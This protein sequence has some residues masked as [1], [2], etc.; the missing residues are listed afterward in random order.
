MNKRH[1]RR[2]KRYRKAW[3]KYLKLFGE[4]LLRHSIEYKGKPRLYNEHTLNKGDIPI[5]DKDADVP[6]V[7]KG[8]DKM[9]IIEVIVP[10]KV[11]VNV[12]DKYLYSSGR[13]QVY[14]EDEKKEMAKTWAQS[15]LSWSILP[16]A[17]PC[18][19][20]DKCTRN[21]GEAF[22]TNPTVNISGTHFV[23]AEVIK[24]DKPEF[25]GKI[26]CEKCKGMNL[27]YKLDKSKIKCGDC[28]TEFD[29]T[30]VPEK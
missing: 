28:N 7:D 16:G 19:G 9:S 26:F 3:F 6:E 30:E 14:S 22:M 21:K 17:I 2:N 15:V 23:K 11:T 20:P 8:E 5:F 12:Q 1:E 10:V 27:F 25:V 24:G 29:N 18:M 13:V 4:L